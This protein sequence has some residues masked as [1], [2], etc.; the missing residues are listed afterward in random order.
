MTFSA[1]PKWTMLDSSGAPVVGGTYY[2]YEAGTSTPKNAYSDAA[3]TIS[4]GASATTDSRGEVG[5]IYL[6]LTASTKVVA[7]DADAN[8]LWTVDNLTA[9]AGSVN[10]TGVSH[11]VSPLDYGAVGDGAA[12]ESSEVQSAIDAATGTVDLAGKTYRCDS[13]LTLPTAG[14][15]SIRDGVID[16]TQN[17]SSSVIEILGSAAAGDALTA[18]VDAGDTTVAIA[19][20]SAYSVGDW[21]LISSTNA[22]G[23]SATRGEIARIKSLTSTVI[24]LDSD[25]RMPHTTGNAAQVSRYT[26]CKNV[27]LD[28]VRILCAYASTQD[29]VSIR[30]AK[31]ITISSCVFDNV[32]D[33]AVS[34]RDA[35]R[36]V[37]TDSLF[38]TSGRGA[39]IG[40]SVLG[41]GVTRGVFSNCTTG[42]Y[43][44]ETGQGTG[45]SQETYV[46]DCSFLGCTTGV[47]LGDLSQGANVDGCSFQGGT[48]GVN[49]Q[50]V[51]SVVRDCRIHSVGGYGVWVQP[52]VG[53][54]Y[55][56]S[57][58]NA[59]DH[60]TIDGCYIEFA[61]VNAI[62]V[63]VN[64]AAVAIKGV[65]IRN[66]KCSGTVQDAINIWVQLGSL[67]RLSIADCA[68]SG[69]D[70]YNAIEIVCASSQS[71]KG[72]TLR[73][74]FTDGPLVIDSGSNDAAEQI[75]VFDS[76]FPGGVDINR[77][78]D[79]H[80]NNVTV[81]DSGT[82][83]TYGILLS[84]CQ[85]TRVTNC[86]VVGSA[87]GVQCIN[88][89]SADRQGAVVSGCYLETTIGG[90]I[91]EHSSTGIIDFVVISNNI[92]APFGTP[93]ADLKAIYLEDVTHAT[94]T[95]N[96][97]KMVA[98]TGDAIVIEGCTSFSVCNNAVI[99]GASAILFSTTASTN[100]VVSGNMLESNNSN[101]GI[102]IE[103]TANI[104]YATISGN[105]IR[106]FGWA[107]DTN[108]ITATEVLA[109]SNAHSYA[110]GGLN[111][112]VTY[113]G[114][115]STSADFKNAKPT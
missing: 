97:I 37:I 77:A 17:T 16:A 53:E 20:T 41:C 83:L 93:S 9:P 23:D 8:T 38:T 75:A 89:T 74:V 65:S 73:G 112:S 21:I 22:W 1:I 71:L 7:K 3:R 29:A 47:N 50:G 61:L 107:I 30:Y 76:S 114:F 91:V 85:N 109:A 31:D 43:V 111:G 39:R 46:S 27:R 104:G 79:I 87:N 10:I 110:S 84:S 49:I 42:V 11:T 100:F 48:Y 24:T 12:D 90:V 108:A 45:L 13:T 51:G 80:L 2:F 67:E 96:T 25:I 113:G 101:N 86:S 69:V 81:N 28:N 5:P 105:Y 34:I 82:A 40:P 44:G 18:S 60:T 58:E 59:T 63:H 6:D 32:N 15:I 19:S 66:T 78:K 70:S 92:K 103:A 55:A 94:V 36:C 64:D 14:N 26:L 88:E 57:G 54:A 106:D 72:V 4:I 95:G 35:I 52:D 62:Y 68:I 99:A 56:F 98:T 102:G 115:S 33:N